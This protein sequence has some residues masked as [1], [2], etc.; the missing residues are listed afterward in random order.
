M[1]VKVSAYICHSNKEGKDHGC[2]PVDPRRTKTGPSEAKQ[3]NCFQGRS[4]SFVNVRSLSPACEK[5]AYCIAA[6]TGG[7]RAV[8]HLGLCGEFSD[9]YE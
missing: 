8:A 9:P 4:C 3:T 6:S 5:K 7:A 2:N 1:A